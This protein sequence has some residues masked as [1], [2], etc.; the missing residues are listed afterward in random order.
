MGGS[1]AMERRALPIWT[2]R[3]LQNIRLSGSAFSIENLYEMDT[4]SAIEM[5][6]PAF[7]ERRSPS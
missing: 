3:D 6:R 4:G 2:I 7:V 1:D 5:S